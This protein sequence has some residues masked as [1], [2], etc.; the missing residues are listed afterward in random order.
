MYPYKNIVLTAFIKCL[1]FILLIFSVVSFAEDEKQATANLQKTFETLKANY[2]KK[3]NNTDEFIQSLDL[4]DNKQKEFSALE[5]KLDECI[6][7]NTKVLNGLKEDLKLL[8]DDTES[9]EDRDIKTER[10][11]LNNQLQTVDNEL[12]RCNLIKIQLENFSEKITKARLDFLK[13]QIFSKEKTVYSS[14]VALLG[15]NKEKTKKGDSSFTPI[16]ENI[17]NSITIKGLLFSFFGVCIGWIWKRK[18]ADHEILPELYASPTFNAV[19]RGCQ[20]TAT[21]LFGLAF[22]WL[23]IRLSGEAES[24]LLSVVRFAFLQTLAFACAR[25][26]VFPQKSL[27]KKQTELRFRLLTLFFLSIVFSTIAYAINQQSLGRFSD[28]FIIFFIWFGSLVISNV[29]YILI[30]HNIIK[31]LSRTIQK[32][33]YLYIPILFLVAILVASFFGYRN[34]SALVFF[35]LILSMITLFL[36]YLLIRLSSEVFDSLDQGKIPWQAK[37]RRL[38]SIEEQRAFPGVV[39][40]RMM[41]F[42]AMLFIAVSSLIT[43]WGGPQQPI[44]SL[45]GIFQ[46]GLTLGSVQLDITN[47]I[48]AMLVMIVTLSLIP[49]IKNKLISGW[50][51]HSNLS[52]GAKDAT[53]TLVGYVVVAIASL[54]A[55]FILGVNF[56]NLAIIAGALSVGIGFGLQN[57]VNNFVS[58]L[59]LL[60]ERPVR[61]GDWI[62]VGNTEGYVRDISIRSTTIQTFD[63]ADVIV[64]NSELISNQVTNWMLSSNIGRLKSSIGVAYGSDVQKVMEVLNDIASAHPEIISNNPAYPTRVFFLAFGDN[65]LNFELRCF[66]KDVDNRLIIQSDVNMSIDAAFREHNI[67]IPFPQRVVHI[68]NND[69]E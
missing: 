50:L 22:L 20:R 38:M 49:F 63:R 58:G 18:E 13:K 24:S 6:A 10:A 26:F 9:K 51:K 45:K 15:V 34:L 64:P 47:I 35:G 43:I 67:E 31:R 40:L 41:S 8:G 33:I 52:S 65:S 21:I 16:L 23:A 56:Q 19:L 46:N 12:K 3:I 1:I 42:F 27:S 36:M 55:L 48:Y 69:D 54:W 66:V 61:R 5:V 25:G 28:S 62:V 60:F 59:I 53:Q 30:L 17:S 7:S 44:A 2:E 14:V 37:L 32:S 29:S 68:K 57:I 11:E 4:I 39:W